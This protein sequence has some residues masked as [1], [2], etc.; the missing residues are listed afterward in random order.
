[1]LPKNE[2]LRKILVVF[3]FFETFCTRVGNSERFGQGKRPLSYFFLSDFPRWCDV[4]CGGVENVVIWIFG[5]LLDG[6]RKGG[7]ECQGV[8]WTST[9]PC[10][11]ASLA[12]LGIFRQAAMQRDHQVAGVADIVWSFYKGRVL[13]RGGGVLCG[14][15]VTGADVASKACEESKGRGADSF[16]VCLSH[17]A[18][19]QTNV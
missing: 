4:G 9:L 12:R 7:W 16:C 15:G 5:R 14:G 2:S 13:V 8:N 17:R 19:V 1:M 6:G 11:L 10:I 18:R 3:S